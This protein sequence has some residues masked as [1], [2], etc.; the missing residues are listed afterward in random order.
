[1]DLFF[2]LLHE[3]MP[4]ESYR[5]AILT[6]DGCAW[7]VGEAFER[8]IV[9]L[10]APLRRLMGPQKEIAALEWDLSKKAKYTRIVVPK[11]GVNDQVAQAARQRDGQFWI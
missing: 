1:V 2:F 4:P 8:T 10:R 3:A 6:G 11:C 9:Q 7:T 5:D